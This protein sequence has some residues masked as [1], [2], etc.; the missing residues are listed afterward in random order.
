MY[1]TCARVTSG[2]PLQPTALDHSLCGVRHSRRSSRGD[3]RI[4]SGGFDRHGL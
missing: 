4:R 3:A 1:R 2:R